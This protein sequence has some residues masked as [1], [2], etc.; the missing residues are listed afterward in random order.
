MQINIQGKGTELTQAL[1][2]YAM[3][4]LNKIEHF[5]HN[6]Q[7]IDIELEVDKIREDAQKQIAKVTV[8]ASGKILHAT[9]ATGNM[10]SSIDL[11][12]DKLEEQVK[13]FKDKLVHERRRESA[14]EKQ[15]L[16]QAITLPEPSEPELEEKK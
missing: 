14:K 4:K 5:F 10:Y 11:I 13:K 1:K 2:D 9:E 15:K 16:H 7:Q 12:M 6:I 8:W 3:K